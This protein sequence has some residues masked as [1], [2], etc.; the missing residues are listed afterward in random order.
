MLPILYLDQ[1][2]VVVYKPSGML[3]HR[4]DIDR[5][6]TLFLLQTLRNQI[7]QHV[8]P[9]H[10]LDK[11]TSGLMVLA[12]HQS[13]ARALTAS[14]TAQN[15]KKH[16]QAL[17]RGWVE[18]QIDLDYALLE[19]QDRKSDRRTRKNKPAQPASSVFIPQQYF[20]TPWP[21]GRYPQGRFT[22]LN[23]QPLSGRKHQLRRHLAHL[24]HPIIGDT[25][26]GDGKQNAYGRE[27]IGIHRLALQCQSLTFPHPAKHIECHFSLPVGMG[28]LSQ[29]STIQRYAIVR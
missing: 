11:P 27:H 18:N 6:E 22:L 8:Y 16:Y 26:H 28:L 21:I 3:V 15:V 20:Q 1:D 4:S 19:I 13:A 12:L 23:C 7:G 25:T 17:V 10:R 5:H 2:I 24:R 14:F 29:M 9:V